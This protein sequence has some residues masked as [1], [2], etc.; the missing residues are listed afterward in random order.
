M[1]GHWCSVCLAQLA[2][3]AALNSRLQKLRTRVVGLN[4]DSHNANAEAAKATGIPLA[5]LSDP[6]HG[7]LEALGL[8]R[9]KANAPMPALVVF[10]EC[11]AEHARIVGRRP[12][13][14][15][16]GS[17]IDVLEKVARTPPRCEGRPN[18]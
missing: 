3:L 9:S 11:G 16:E 14:R 18:A 5:I 2:R 12:G 17:V 7:V 15:V 4:A 10:D 1:K 8:W 6:E 13:E